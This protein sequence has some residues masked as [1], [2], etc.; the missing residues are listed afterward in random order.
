MDS[1]AIS[2]LRP[3]L[4]MPGAT[5]VTRL[6]VYDT[7]APDGQRGGTPHFHFLR[8]EM[9]FVLAGSGAVEM[10][11]GNGFSRIELFPHSALTFSPGTIHRLINPNGDLE[12]LVVMQNSG[13]PERGD[14]VV[15][16]TTEWLAD[17]GRFA[18][19]MMV[20]TLEDAYRRR[21]RGVEGFLQLKVVFQQDREAGRKALKVFYQRAAERTAGLR[22]QWQRIVT[23]GVLAEVQA[24]LHHL[25]A[26]A[27]AQVDYLFNA[28]HHLIHASD[29]SKPGFCGHLYRYFDPATLSPEG[30]T[31]K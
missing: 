19:A 30:I 1:P 2:P 11:D 16:F 23:G 26:L 5:L 3:V 15:C 18:E 27:D 25:S 17:D 22:E 4:R 8:T 13:L 10:I 14:N 7:V 20:N 29:Y 12:L 28:Q 24:S 6:K 21:D 9:Y 31:Q